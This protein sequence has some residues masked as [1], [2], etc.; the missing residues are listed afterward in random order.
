MNKGIG[1]KFIDFFE[2]VSFVDDESKKAFLMVGN[3]NTTAISLYKKLGY[4]QVGAVPD[5]YVSG[6]TEYLMMKARK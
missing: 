1:K 3:F 5:L 2:Y 4:I 6:I